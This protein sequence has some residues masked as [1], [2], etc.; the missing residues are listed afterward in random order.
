L[1]RVCSRVLANVKSSD[2]N[3]TDPLSEIIQSLQAQEALPKQE[4]PHHKAQISSR[5]APKPV[6]SSRY[7]VAA[8]NEVRPKHERDDAGSSKLHSKPAFTDS[9]VCQPMSDQSNDEA[10]WTIR[11]RM[12]SRPKTSA[13]ACI[14]YTGENSDPSSRPSN[15]T[16]Y[17]TYSTPAT[18]IGHITAGGKRSYTQDEPAMPALD[19]YGLPSQGDSP[20]RDSAQVCAWMDEQFEHRHF[21][22]S[23]GFEYPTNSLREFYP[24]LRP[25][26]AEQLRQRMKRSSIRDKVQEYFRPGSSASN[27]P[28]RSSVASSI[29]NYIRPGSA[30]GSIRSITTDTSTRSRTQEHW[31][32]IKRRLSNASRFSQR[33]NRKGAADGDPTLPGESEIDLNR[34]LPPLPGLDSYKEKKTHIA[35][36][37][38]KVRSPKIDSSPAQ[39]SIG[40]DYVV[41]PDDPTRRYS[42]LSIPPPFN[43]STGSIGSVPT[44]LNAPSFTSQS[45]S[46]LERFQS[47]TSTAKAGIPVGV[48]PLSQSTTPKAELKKE[49]FAKRWGGKF[50]LGKKQKVVVAV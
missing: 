29:K 38:K 18:S 31:S 46:S 10:L 19:F 7:H 23:N 22:G 49:G 3:G 40:S 27:A 33:I 30:A 20:S 36:L 5:N 25:E 2:D 12:S 41:I 43:M 44:S 28:R 4:A 8:R 50:S 26:E 34:P 14:D 39:G 13:A 17:T 11:S 9:P 45:R 42:N 16:T 21:Q 32:S 1:K 37:M 15:R 24:T 48:S 6:T 35:S 47:R